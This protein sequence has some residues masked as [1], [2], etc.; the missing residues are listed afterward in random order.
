MNG[1]SVLDRFG[2]NS[3]SDELQGSLMNLGIWEAAFIADNISTIYNG[4]IVLDVPIL[5]GSLI[6]FYYLGNELS[7]L[8]I[9]DEIPN[10]TVVSSSFGSGN[11]HLTAQDG[12]SIVQGFDTTL[13]A[14]VDH[15][16]LNQSNVIMIP[17]TDLTGSQRNIITRFSAPGGP[18]VQSIGYLDAYTTTYSVHN[19]LPYRNSSVLGSG[20]GEQ[21]TIRVEDHLGHRRGLKTLRA[22]HMGKFGSDATYGIIESESYVVQGS[23]N[24]QHRN[25]SNAYIWN[26]SADIIASLSET[27][28]ITGSNYDNMHINTSIPRSELQYSWIHNATSGAANV[29]HGAPTQRI[30]GYAPRDGIVSSSA[31][32]V[33]AIVFPTASSI[34]SF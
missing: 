18:E 5:Q 26:T 10:G 7:G 6:D 21:G 13:R 16:P 30:L 34:F 1:I 2:S 11:N 9:G 17:R 32:Y 29:A 23:F 24:K 28:L 12:L 3:V 27:D 22:L 15:I 25:E 33:E 31:G 14:F 4:G 8:S 20:S 19:V